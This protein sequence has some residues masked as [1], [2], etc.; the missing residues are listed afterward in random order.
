MLR[1]IAGACCDSSNATSGRRWAGGWRREEL[2]V[3]DIDLFKG[4]RL[5]LIGDGLW[6]MVMLA[7]TL[8]TFEAWVSS[9]EMLIMA[10]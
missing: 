6:Y 10:A 9:L 1:R 4:K 2:M 5:S 8:E 3:A 7:S